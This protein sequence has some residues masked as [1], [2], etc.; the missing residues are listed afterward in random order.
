MTLLI[1]AGAVMAAAWLASVAPSLPGQL[2]RQGIA[3]KIGDE[4]S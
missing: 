2:C 4:R 1:K 3:T